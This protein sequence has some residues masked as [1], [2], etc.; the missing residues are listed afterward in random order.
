MTIDY[1]FGWTPAMEARIDA[2]IKAKKDAATKR[3]TQM[4][5]WRA[6]ATA[7][8]K[9]LDER[10]AKT[11]AIAKA[12]RAGKKRAASRLR[13]ITEALQLLTVKNKFQAK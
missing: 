11:K 8:Q 7:P 2:R 9:K 13:A 4:A 12:R 5:K 6:A 10:L 1:A 3:K